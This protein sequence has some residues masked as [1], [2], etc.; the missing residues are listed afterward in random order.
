MTY[1][2][3][4][5]FIYTYIDSLVLYTYLYNNYDNLPNVHGLKDQTKYFLHRI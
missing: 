4:K 5:V 1:L 3:L 2:T